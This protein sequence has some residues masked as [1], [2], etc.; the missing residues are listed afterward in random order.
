MYF[1]EIIFKLQQFWASKGCAVCNPYDAEKGAGTMN[2]LTFFKTLGDKPWNVCYVEPSRRPKD[3]R[4]GEN[5]NRL[6][7]HHQMQVIMKPS[8]EN[9]VDLYLESLEYLGIDKSKHDIRLVEDNWESP[10]LGAF[11]MGWEIWLDGMEITQFTFFQQMAGYECKPVS[12][13]ITYG[14]E[15]LAMYLQNK[16]NIF[17]IDW[18]ENTKYNDI[19]KLPEYEHS[20]YSFEVCDSEFL[21]DL[22]NKYE[23]EAERILSHKLVMPAYDYFLKCSHSFNVLDA[24]GAISVTERA[25]FIG[26]IRTLARKIATEYLS[27]IDGGQKDND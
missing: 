2:P 10:T 15:R 22:F 13:E 20:V 16:D 4:Y 6:Y 26:R 9:I 8:P 11:G 19:F 7:Q 25:R 1:Q 17:D 27:K 24:R 14:L 12:A 18:N 21:L 5:P 23:T 3:G